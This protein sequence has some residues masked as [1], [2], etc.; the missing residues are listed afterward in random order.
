MTDASYAV[1]MAGGKG[2]RFWPASTDARPKQLLA[3]SGDRPL[4]AN[5][6]DR[7]QGLIPPERILIVTRADLVE[8]IAACNPGLPRENIVGEPCGRD[9]AAACALGLALV[10]RRDPKAAFAILT[11]DHVIRDVPGFHT[12][13]RDCFRLALTEDVLVTMGI[14]PAFA[15]TGFGY[16]EC[17]DAIVSHSETGFFRA[18]RFVE[19]PDRPAAERYRAAGNYFWNSG[20]FVWSVSAFEKALRAHRPPLAAMAERLAATDGADRFAALLEKEYAGLDR[21]S[22][23]YAVMEKADN[24]VMARGDFGWDDIGSWS[25]IA[26]YCEA[27]A[28]GNAL[29]GRGAAL[30]AKNTLVFARD[31]ERVTALIGVRDLVVVHTDRATLICPK[32]RAEEVKAMT[33]LLKS[34]GGFED[35]L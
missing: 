10:K 34:R 13:L 19:K 2:Q 33:D 23:D 20:M 12:A 22:V 11:A 31:T 6:V 1:I 27:D 9:T 32:D 17:G 21:I 26:T 14:V 18:R 4:V 35:V 28:D 29:V 15:S 3:L 16:I 25:A 7:L 24:I 5:S 30:D 8:P